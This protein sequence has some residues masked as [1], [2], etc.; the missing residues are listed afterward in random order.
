MAITRRGGLLNT[1][2]VYM[3]KIAIGPGY[4]EGLVDLDMPPAEA[5]RRLAEAKGVRPREVSACILDRP[6]H[7]RLVEAVRATGASIRLIGDGDLAGV[8]H[9]TDPEKTGIDIYLGIGGAPEGVL[10]AAALRCIGGQMHGRLVLDTEAKRER[11]E[12]LGLKGARHV[13]R[14]EDMASGDVLFAATG[15]TDGNLLDGVLFERGSVTTHSVVTRSHTRTQRWVKAIHRLEKARDSAVPCWASGRR[16]MADLTDAELDA[17]A[18]RGVAAHATEPRASSAKSDRK[19]RRIVVTLTNGCTF[20]FPP[21][22]AQGLES[23]NDDALAQVEMLGAG[24]G[25]R[26]EKL[27]VDLS[28]PGLL[29]GIFGTRAYMA[30]RAGRATSPAKAAAARVNGAKGGRPRRVAGR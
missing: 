23:A 24:Y 21:N 4:P 27:D 15:V 6:R 14:T 3:E 13:Y 18:E 19:A 17:A 28:V 30:R 10:A 29:A 7:A 25:L 2:D 9:T 20:T 12:E 1:P 16:S 5:I 11:A 26:W 22:L 8:I